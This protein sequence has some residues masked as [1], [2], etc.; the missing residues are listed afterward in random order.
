VT[1][2][3]FGKIII[4]A[5]LGAVGLVIVRNTYGRRAW[6]TRHAITFGA[7]FTVLLVLLFILHRVGLRG[8]WVRYTAISLATPV[9]F[10]GPWRWKPLTSKDKEYRENRKKAIKRWEAET[11]KIFNSRTH[12]VDHIVPLRRHGGHMIDN[13]RVIKISAN[14][15][16]GSREP[17][18]QD[19]FNVWRRKD[20]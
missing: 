5:L 15:K 17:S 9:Y 1:E 14:R 2:E 16:K 13:L 19:W 11:G 7:F 12:E 10:Y 20:E 4:F 8:W 18:L 3:L 6:L